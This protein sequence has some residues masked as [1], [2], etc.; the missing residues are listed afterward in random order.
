MTLCIF[1]GNAIDL[2]SAFLHI[3]CF[4][5]HVWLPS[6]FHHSKCFLDWDHLVA[7]FYIWP[8]IWSGLTPYSCLIIWCYRSDRIFINYC[9]N[10][11]YYSNIWVLFNRAFRLPFE[12]KQFCLCHRV[13]TD[14]M[15]NQT[16]YFIGDK[17]YH[18]CFVSIKNVTMFVLTNH[19]ANF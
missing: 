16:H 13:K 6:L 7:D 12:V 1:I 3:S 17:W 9:S 5:N 4:Q 10:N 11:G 2:L 15:V 14:N 18:F 19:S 8:N